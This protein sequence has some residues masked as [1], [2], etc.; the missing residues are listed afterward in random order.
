MQLDADG[1]G[2]RQFGGHRAVGFLGLLRRN[3][4]LGVEPWQELLEEGI[5][6]VDGACASQAQLG[7]QP[8]LES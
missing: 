5:G 2:E 3:G 1:L 8:V 4:E 6:L 7:D